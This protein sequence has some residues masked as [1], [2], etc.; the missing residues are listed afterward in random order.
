MSNL[1]HRA[2]AAQQRLDRFFNH[3]QSLFLLVLRLYWGGRFFLAGW[4]KLHNLDGVVQFF[5]S[6]GIP[7]PL[8]NAWA[9]SLTECL[10]GLLLLV[11]LASRIVSIPLIGTMVV[12]LATAHRAET[13]AIFAGDPSTFLSALPITYLLASLT[14]LVFG[15]GSL[16]CDSLITGGFGTCA[17][18]M[19]GV[20][21][22]AINPTSA[23]SS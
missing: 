11:G 22:H 10:G 23:K 7:A 14:I 8:F 17:K 16:A 2:N 5:D 15:P 13:A 3:G 20:Q 9:A 1:L 12:A 4:G 6:L 21:P 18:T 19:N